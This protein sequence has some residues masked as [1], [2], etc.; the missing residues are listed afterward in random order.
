MEWRSNGWSIHGRQHVHELRDATF[1][2]AFAVRQ[3]EIGIAAMLGL[4]L[5]VT[6]VYLGAA[7]LGD[8]NFPRWFS[9][10]AIVGGASMAAA[11]IVTAL[12]GFSHLEMAIS[13]PANLILV[14]WVAT[15]AILAWPRDG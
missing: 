11:G 9:W 12:E 13:M 6:S 1:Q 8:G 10:L 4:M 7:L 15:L 2:A 3:T 5:G 14:S